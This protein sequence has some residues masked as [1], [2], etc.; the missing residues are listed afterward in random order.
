MQKAQIYDL[1]EAIKA[2]ERK[3]EIAKGNR[4]TRLQNQRA[5]AASRESSQAN[6]PARW[7]PGML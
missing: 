5:A 6:R 4:K 3:I 7:T 2:M 1:R